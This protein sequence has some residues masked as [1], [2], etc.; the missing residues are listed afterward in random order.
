MYPRLNNLASALLNVSCSHRSAR[1]RP[2]GGM[3]R[4]GLTLVELLISLSIMSLIA[5]AVGM[6]ARAV[7]M[8]T[9]YTEQHGD[10]TQQ[11][12]V[13]LERIGRAVDQATANE[14]YPGAVVFEES[15]GSWRYPDTLVVWRPATA[16][17]NSAGLPLFRELV[18]FCPNPLV[19]NELLEI[20]VPNDARQVPPLSSAN[21]WQIEIAAL[22]SASGARRVVLSNKIRV[23]GAG[24]SS[25]DRRGAVR[26]EAERR[27]SAT[28]WNAYRAGTVAW[29]NVNWVQG[30]YGSQTGLAQTWVRAELQLLPVRS[31][32]TASVEQ[33]L[34]MPGSAAVY[35]QLSR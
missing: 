12:R 14:N 29:E 26:F 32:A 19:P 23:A 11:A 9:D 15:V 21:T 18:V 30:I 27:P 20:T 7:Q 17:A 4:S 28:Q 10:A 34:P 22:K 13:A 5:G 16:A 31:G 8:S 35:F 25:S 6:L 1:R 33:V 24:G 2:P 3:S